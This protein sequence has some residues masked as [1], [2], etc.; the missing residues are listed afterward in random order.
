MQNMEIFVCDYYKLFN[1]LTFWKIRR[2]AIEDSLKSDEYHS[3]NRTDKTNLPARI[4]ILIKNQNLLIKKFKTSSQKQWKKVK[5]FKTEW[6]YL[7]T[8]EIKYRTSSVN[9]D[10]EGGI[11]KR[12]SFIKA[13]DLLNITKHR[14]K[15]PT[16]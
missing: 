4:F 13:K 2:W 10:H 16:Y 15:R 1:E 3:K 6:D 5:Q 7:T 12:I 11:Y 14:W 9:T 8:S